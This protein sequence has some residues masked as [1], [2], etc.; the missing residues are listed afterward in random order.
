MEEP[1]Q[2]KNLRVLLLNDDTIH[3]EKLAKV[4]R[5]RGAHTT[6]ATVD[7]L[8]LG[9]ARHLDPQIVVCDSQTAAS[10]GGQAL[11]ND[12]QIRWATFLIADWAQLWP[13]TASKPDVD[14]IAEQLLPLSAPDR[15]L[16][17]LAKDKDVCSV[18]FEELGPSRLLRA[19]RS[20]FGTRHVAIAGS[21]HAIDFDLADGLVVGAYASAADGPAEALQGPNAISL[22]WEVEKGEV[23]IRKQAL[24]SIVNIMSPVDETLSSAIRKLAVTPQW[25]ITDV[26]LASSGLPPPN[27]VPSYQ[28]RLD[29]ARKR[30]APQLGMPAMAPQ[31]LQG[32]REIFDEAP[33]RQFDPSDLPETPK[34]ASLAVPPVTQWR[35][36]N[37]PSTP[38]AIQQSPPVPQPPAKPDP[39]P[40]AIIPIPDERTKGWP[41]L[42]G[43]ILGA[44]ALLI[45]LGTFGYRQWKGDKEP[46]PI[47][48][49]TPPVSPP[50]ASPTTPKPA[51]ASSDVNVDAPTNERPAQPVDIR[52]YTKR[53]PH[54]RARASDVLLG[55]ALAGEGDLQSAKVAWHRALQ[56]DRTNKDARERLRN[57]AK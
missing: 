13:S 29:A 44:S 24:P 48:Q 56:E 11:Q 31:T 32:D 38:T 17:E 23:E 41:T 47:V 52:A 37:S 2:L 21:A 46:E 49:S 8:Q 54:D 35:A 40:P 1:N 30:K 34:R 16:R 22:L 53:L 5:L 9:K 7:P 19:L 20:V 25:H 45:G 43:L 51:T 3:A 50:K 28:V 36:A 12:P 14:S 42:I 27:P 6:T 15:R 10:A 57:Q 39:Q 33:T 55:D 26:V 18:R 4:L